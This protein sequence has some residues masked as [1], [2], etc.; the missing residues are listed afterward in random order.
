MD[1]KDALKSSLNPPAL[2]APT[3]AKRLMAFSPVYSYSAPPIDKPAI[4]RM[5]RSLE[6]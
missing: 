5:A 4:A 1:G 6:A 2:N 3:Q